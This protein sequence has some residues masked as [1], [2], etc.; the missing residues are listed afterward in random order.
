[1]TPAAA[2][3]AL[4]RLGIGAAVFT[5]G[6]EP[7]RTDPPPEAQ[8]P[9]GAPSAEAPPRESSPAAGV[10]GPAT[11]GPVSDAS[12]VPG[13]Y[14]A[15]GE[16]DPG[17]PDGHGYIVA[18][19]ILVPLGLLATV[20]GGV[21]VYLFDPARCPESL[22]SYDLSVESCRGLFQYNIAQTAYGAGMLISGSVILAIGLARRSKFRAWQREHGLAV[23][24]WLRGSMGGG[25]PAGGSP[26]GL[27]ASGRRRSGDTGIGVRLA[28]RF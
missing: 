15:I 20:S 2:A 1:M 18:G 27:R 11:G 7:D 9:S 21:F 19:S 22:P 28:F 24:P 4:T 6:A 3:L 10:P 16:R 23:M 12:S 26:A 13:A 25:S 8:D 17:P 5:P 14:W